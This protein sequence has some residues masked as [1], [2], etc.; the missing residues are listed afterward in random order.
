MIALNTILLNMNRVSL[1]PVTLTLDAVQRKGAWSLP[2]L[3]VPCFGSRYHVLSLQLTCR[4]T[5][6]VAFEGLY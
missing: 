6:C 3:A 4:V 2:L 1:V 5:E